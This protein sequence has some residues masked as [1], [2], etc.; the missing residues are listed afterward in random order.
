MA[1]KDKS[2]KILGGNTEFID[3][4]DTGLLHFTLKHGT[5]FVWFFP[6]TSIQVTNFGAQVQLTYQRGR[7]TTV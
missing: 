2:Q 6:T 3:H 4:K 5:G 1:A 7:S